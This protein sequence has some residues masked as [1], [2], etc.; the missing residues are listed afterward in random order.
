M[1]PDAGRRWAVVVVPA[2]G[3]VAVVLAV[4]LLS[5]AD[6]AADQGG[7][8]PTT[9][10]GGFGIDAEGGHLEFDQTADQAVVGF[11][12]PDATGTFSYD[13]DGDG[14]V[15]EGEGGT[16]ELAPGEPEGWPSF[17]VPAGVEAVRGSTLDAGTLVQLSTTYRTDAP[18]EEVVAYYED[19]LADASPLVEPPTEAEPS[20]TISFEGAWSGFVTVAAVEGYTVLSVQLEVEPSP[21]GG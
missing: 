4:V 20:T 7:G 16:F 5:T 11:D 2:V 8:G 17:P 19:A 9:T 18:A 21:V 6:Q 10:D 12:A 14:I 15:T 3:V 13:L 1:A